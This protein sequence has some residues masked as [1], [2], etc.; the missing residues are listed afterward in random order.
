MGSNP[1]RVRAGQWTVV[2]GEQDGRRK[3]QSDGRARIS[4]GDTLRNSVT[5]YYM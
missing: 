3:L 5:V 1:D 4:I 2:I